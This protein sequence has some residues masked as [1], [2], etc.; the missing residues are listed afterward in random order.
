MCVHMVKNFLDWKLAA[1]RKLKEL[2][3]EYKMSKV[4]QWLAL[5]IENNAFYFHINS[6]FCPEGTK[7]SQAQTEQY[8]RKND[9]VAQEVKLRRSTRHLI[10]PQQYF[11]YP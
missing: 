4:F 1:I 3:C 8:L 7:A 10:I 2:L 6:C 5:K 11:D 9:I